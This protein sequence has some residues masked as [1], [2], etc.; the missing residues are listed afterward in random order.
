MRRSAWDL[1]KQ[2]QST[3]RSPNTM[4]LYTEQAGADS[5]N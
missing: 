3:T 1:N 4:C 2:I 5:V